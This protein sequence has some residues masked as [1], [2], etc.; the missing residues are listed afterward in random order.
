MRIGNNPDDIVYQNNIARFC[1]TVGITL[2]VLEFDSNVSNEEFI[3]KF[4]E[5]NNDKFVDGILI[6]RPIPM[7]IDMEYIKNKIDHRKDIDGIGFSNMA[8]LYAG[9]SNVIAPCTAEAVV[10]LLDYY[11][12]DLTGKLVTVLGRSLVVG[13]PVAMLLLNRNATVNICHSN[14]LNIAEI[15]KKSDIIVSCVGNAKFVKEN[16]V[17]DKSIVIDVGI[18]IDEEGEVC[19][20]VDFEKVEKIVKAITPVPRGVGGITNVILAKHVV[21]SA[22]RRKNIY[23]I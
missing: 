22:N 6:F 23:N 13:K 16:F 20:D 8:T 18:N 4:D 3:N 10:A 2:D 11:N 21:E 19:G 1:G 7:H 5:V 9:D 12:I 14:T 15:C 17:N